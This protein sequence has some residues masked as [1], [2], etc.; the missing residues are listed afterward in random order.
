MPSTTWFIGRNDRY[1]AGRVL[2]VQGSRP[3]MV[4]ASQRSWWV[5]ATP[6]GRP[7]VPEV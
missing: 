2:A 1:S 7:V 6:L 3:A 5:K 4:S